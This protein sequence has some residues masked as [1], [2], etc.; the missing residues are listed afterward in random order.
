M[1]KLYRQFMRVL[2]LVCAFMFF[3]MFTVSLL[4]VVFRYVFNDS[5]SWTEEM[6]RYLFVWISFLGGAV[7]MDRGGNIKIDI[8][9]NMLRNPLR[10]TVIVAAKISILAFLTGLA[11]SGVMIVGLTMDQPSAVMQIPMGLVYAAIPTGAIAMAIV[12]VRGLFPN[13]DPMIEAPQL[14]GL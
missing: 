11:V 12:M 1:E 7:V 4:Q 8:L 6:A 14:E 9:E 13:G 3:S 10:Q 5:L 2:D